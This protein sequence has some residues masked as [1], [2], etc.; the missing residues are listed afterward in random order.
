LKASTSTSDGYV[1]ASPTI[2]TLLGKRGVALTD[3]RP[4]GA[5]LIDGKRTDVLTE[6]SFI[7]RGTAVRVIRVEGSGV[8]VTEDEDSAGVQQ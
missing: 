3:L 8:V 7:K 5:A 4:S 6:G 1:S 2:N